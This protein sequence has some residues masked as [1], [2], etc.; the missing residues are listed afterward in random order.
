MT[1]LLASV[2]S[3]GEARLA[4]RAGADIVDCKDP[5]EGA[6]GALPPATIARI[7]AASGDQRPTSATTGDAVTS[8]RRLVEAVRN[9]ADCGV[10]FIKFGLFDLS[11]AP[12]MLSALDGLAPDHDLIAVCF[13][14]L[15]D[16]T[17]LITPLAESGVRGIMLDTANKHAGSLTTL[18]SATRIAA[19]VAAAQAR[20]RLCGLAGRLGLRDIPALLPLQADY[21]GFRGALCGGERRRGI[22]HAA[23]LRVRQAIP[24]QPSRGTSDAAG[25]ALQ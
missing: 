7:V 4:L 24:L 3:P 13:V 6:L 11:S 10:D 18:W 20:G 1:G 8:A 12:C 19:F 23:L 14:D 9:T 21:L 22:D 5:H 25:V 15:F 16:P 17:P 2:R